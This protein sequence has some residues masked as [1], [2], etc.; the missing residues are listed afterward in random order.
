[1]DLVNEQHVALLQIRQQRGQI[2]RFFNGRAR[3][4]ANL[5]AHLV[6]HN[7]GQRGF[8]KARRAV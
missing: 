2:A 5:H 8:A 3:G 7:A 1:M 6:R 4:D